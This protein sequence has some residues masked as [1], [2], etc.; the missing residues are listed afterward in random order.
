MNNE[1]DELLKEI[2]NYLNIINVLSEEEI[3]FKKFSKEWIDIE[4]RIIECECNLVNLFVLFQIQRN[5]DRNNDETEKQLAKE[6]LTLLPVIG[7]HLYKYFD[8]MHF[9]EIIETSLS[10]SSRVLIDNMIKKLKQ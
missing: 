2:T 7:L 3:Q 4:Q 6:L 5:I 10:K 8:N 1:S 9:K